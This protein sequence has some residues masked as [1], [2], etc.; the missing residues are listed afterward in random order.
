METIRC[1]EAEN[2]LELEQ[3]AHHTDILFLHFTIIALSGPIGTEPGISRN[4]QY[5]FTKARPSLMSI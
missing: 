1:D 5:A 3:G 2:E 4:T